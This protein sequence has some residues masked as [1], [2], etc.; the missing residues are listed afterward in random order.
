MA[1]EPYLQLARLT[2]SFGQ[3]PVLD[4][5]SL[6]VQRG[7]TLVICGPSGCGKSTLLRCL[8]GLEPVESGSLRLDGRQLDLADGRQRQSAREGTGLV[9]QNFNL[10][11]HMRV[12]DNLT[13]APRRVRGLSKRQARDEALE[14]LERVGLAER[15]RAFPFELSGGQRQRVAIARALAMKPKLLMFDEPTSALDPEKKDEVLGV[16]RTLR[17]QDAVTMIVVTH[18]I[19]F[20]RNVA[21]R[22]ILLEDGRI[23]EEDEARIFFEAPREERTRRFLKAII[24]A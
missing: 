14:L 17:E 9:F 12:L 24:N 11:P 16:I 5:V 22:A 21:D 2:K 10:F 7:E 23:V 3:R 19:G 8:N 20:G 6:S 13:L 15:A 1:D 18:E 4:E